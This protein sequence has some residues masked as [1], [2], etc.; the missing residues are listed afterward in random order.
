[1]KRPDRFPQKS[2][3]PSR[4]S[5]TDLRLTQVTVKPVR[6]DDGQL[7]LALEHNNPPRPITTGMAKTKPALVPGNLPS[8]R[9]FLSVEGQ[10]VILSSVKKAE[11]SEA[12]ILRLYNPSD[13]VA[14]ATIQF[15]FI[16]S[17]VRLAGLDEQP[18]ADTSAETNLVLESDSV[19]RIALAP[20]K[21][22]T[23]RMDRA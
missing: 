3:Q 7:R 4:P 5:F 6:S 17:N 19:V 20:R 9:S 10:N 14:Q 18:Q 22:I 11:I 12:L 2:D 8:S 23:L 1:M 21:I 13:V 16:P 15:P